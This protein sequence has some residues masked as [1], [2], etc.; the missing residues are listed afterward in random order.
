MPD[1]SFPIKITI[2]ADFHL[3]SSPAKTFLN[4]LKN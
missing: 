4:N 1:D 2:K 3:V